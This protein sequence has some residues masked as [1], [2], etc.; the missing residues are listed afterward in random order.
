MLVM[1]AVNYAEDPKRLRLREP[2]AAELDP[3]GPKQPKKGK[4]KGKGK[5][6]EKGQRP[7]VQEDDL[8]APIRPVLHVSSG[9]PLS[10]RPD[11]IVFGLK[12]NPTF[13]HAASR[14]SLLPV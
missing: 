6:T 12:E 11:I 9:K 4:G 7:E 3:D 2:T 5:K 10:D 13:S 8:D 14:V 1:L